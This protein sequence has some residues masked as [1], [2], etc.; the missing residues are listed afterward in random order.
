[1]NLALNGGVRD[2]GNC[3]RGGDD[4]DR[5]AAELGR[6]GRAVGRSAGEHMRGG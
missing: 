4:E 2:G 6:R 3:K 1:M 5:F